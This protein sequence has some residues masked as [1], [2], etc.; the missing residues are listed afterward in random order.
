V[1]IPTEP[2]VEKFTFK[3]VIEFKGMDQDMNDN[4]QNALDQYE[5]FRA[6]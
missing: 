3:N 2:V 5:V 6:K 1:S 4:F